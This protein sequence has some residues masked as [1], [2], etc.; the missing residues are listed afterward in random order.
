MSVNNTEN[1]QPVTPIV[2]V[3]AGMW[4]TLQVKVEQLWESEHPSIR[5]LGVFT[6]DTGIIKFVSWEK[7]NLPL[8]EEGATYKVGKVPVTAFEGRF[9]V[10][11]V[12]ITTITRVENEEARPEEI[13]RV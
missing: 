12:S 5:Q 9:Q 10:A 7:A 6:D 3:T 1:N 2:H 8:M 13:P 4:P 11:L